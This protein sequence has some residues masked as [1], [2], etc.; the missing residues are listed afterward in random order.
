MSIF[1]LLSDIDRNFEHLNFDLEDYEPRPFRDD[2]TKVTVPF[3]AN[4]IGVHLIEYRG[5]VNGNAV[6][7]AITIDF[8]VEETG[9]QEFLFNCYQNLYCDSI[10]YTG[11]VIAACQSQADTTANGIPDLAQ[12]WDIT[13]PQETS[14]LDDLKFTVESSEIDEVILNADPGPCTDGV[15][16][17]EFNEVTPGDQVEPAGGTLTI[18][19]TSYVVDMTSQGLYKA[20]PTIT[21]RNNDCFSVPDFTV[22]LYKVT[23]DL[24]VYVAA[25]N[26]GPVRP[27]YEKEIGD[28]FHLAMAD[29]SIVTNDRLAVVSEGSYYCKGCKTAIVNAVASSSGSGKI[30]YQTCWDSSNPEGTAILITMQIV[31]GVSYTLGN[32]LEDTITIDNDTLDVD[33]QI[34]IEPYRPS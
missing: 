4:T 3:I 21:V 29:A 14:T 25:S 7:N 27:I 15:Y 8:N 34:A 30:S 23:I 11:Y 18:S 2:L 31:A 17:L 12:T 24:S 19:G 28:V 10:T 32:L 13:I 9:P 20:A 6:T 22:T 16:F 1:K 5:F 33:A 26:L